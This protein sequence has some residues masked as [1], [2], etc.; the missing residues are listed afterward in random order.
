MAL[1]DP[2]ARLDLLNRGQGWVVRKLRDV[3]PRVR[4][5]DLRRDLQ[6]MLA[7]HERNIETCTG[8]SAG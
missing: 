8:L 7:V 4:D 1:T 5:I 3:L 6:E 2:G